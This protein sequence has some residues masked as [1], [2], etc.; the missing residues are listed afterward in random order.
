MGFNTD[1]I[2]PQELYSLSYRIQQALPLK[3]LNNNRLNVDQLTSLI[4]E[5]RRLINYSPRS[6]KNDL[7]SE[8]QFYHIMDLIKNI[9]QIL[10]AFSGHF[11]HLPKLKAARGDVDKIMQ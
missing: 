1:E 2:V 8:K 6:K 4:P 5:F 3:P 9:E 10:N 7:T 11:K